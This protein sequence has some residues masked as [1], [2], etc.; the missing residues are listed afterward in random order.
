MKN[1]FNNAAYN[2]GADVDQL[3]FDA[4]QTPPGADENPAEKKGFY[5]LPYLT[6]VAIVWVVFALMI[7]FAKMGY[8]IANIGVFFMLPMVFGVLFGAEL[9][10]RPYSK[11]EQ[12]DEDEYYFFWRNR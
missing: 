3:V 12:E 6:R 10:I 8:G 4:V 1:F 7:L 2:T 11:K 5:G 9:Y